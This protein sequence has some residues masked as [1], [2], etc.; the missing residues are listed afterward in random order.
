MMNK[1]TWHSSRTWIIRTTLAT[2]LFLSIIIAVYY[3]TVNRYNKF[4][5]NWEIVEVSNTEASSSLEEYQMFCIS[6]ASIGMSS[7]KMVVLIEGTYNY[8]PW[9]PIACN[10][11]KRGGFLVFHPQGNYLFTDRRESS[12]NFLSQEFEVHYF[13]K[14]HYLIINNS[15]FKR[16]KASV[17]W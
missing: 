9:G 10:A 1:M 12:F 15:L 3:L 8:D 2:V 4:V 16:S 5:G 17:N 13:K 7:N 14:N 6:H 11:E